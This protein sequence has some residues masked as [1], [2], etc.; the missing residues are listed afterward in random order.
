MSVTTERELAGSIALVTGS[1]SGIG[2]A[3]AV[4]L[5]RSG[6]TLVVSGRDSA[7]GDR[8]VKA[9]SEAG[10]DARFVAADLSRP[11]DVQRLAEEAGPVD[12]LVNNAGFSWFGPT[13][14]LDVATFDR[15]FAA[16]VRSAYLL[17]AAVSPGMV[18]RGHGSIVNLSSM[19]S[20]V[21][22]AGGAAY[23]ATKASLAA[24]TRAWAAEFAAAGVRVNAVSPGPVHSE[25]SDQDV[26]DGL[27]AGTLL[28]RGGQPEEVA[29]AIAYLVSPRAAY[30]TGATLAVDGG[31][32]A[33]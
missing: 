11:E 27:A 1:T 26:I 22:L 18:K 23:S 20:T 30:V 6:A 14:E 33:V 12:I 16:N 19:A 5:A 4:R 15:L 2:R 31:R 25:G 29:D 13:A 32:T 21:G 7:R 8:V 3:T 10:G 28:G 24:F 17:T 9:I